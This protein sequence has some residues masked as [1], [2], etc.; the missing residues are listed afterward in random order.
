M[1]VVVVS[2]EKEHATMTS[3]GRIR[4][5]DNP[6]FSG[7]E[8][9]QVEPEAA[10]EAV[11]YFEKK[12]SELEKYVD[13]TLR[14]L[15]QEA[16]KKQATE[17][18][19]ALRQEVASAH[20]I[21]DFQSLLER[22]DRAVSSLSAGEDQAQSSAPDATD[23]QQPVADTAPESAVAAEKTAA[24]KDEA[25]EEAPE[26]AEKA[27]EQAEE[28]PEPAEKTEEQAES[29]KTIK[30]EDYPESLAP[31]VELASKASGLAESSEWGQTQSEF[32]NIRLKW[33][34]TVEAGESLESEEGYSELLKMRDDAEAHFK[35]RKQA[36]QQKRSEQKKANLEKRERILD[37]LQEMIDKKKWQAMK[38]FNHITSRW[39]EI[40]D[41]PKG[42]EAGQQDKRFAE[43]VKQ[44]NDNKVAFLVKKAEKEEENLTG[45]LAVLDKM[46]QLVGS[47]SPETTNWDQ[48]DAEEEEL[49]KQ[50]RK[51]G[52]VPMDQSDQIWDQ[53]KS[54]RDEYVNKKLE[55]NEAFRNHTTKNIRKKTQL[56]EKAEELLEAE[57]LTFAVR[58]I[59]NL[60]KKWKKVGLIPKEKNDELW[61]R[62]NAATRKFNEIKSENQ[63]TIKQQE[64]ANLDKKI[65]LCEKAEELQDSTNWNEI[66]RELDELMKRWKD[67]GPVPRR[68]SG[69]VWKRFKN[70]MD[71]FYE[72]RRKHYRVVREEQKENYRKKREIVSEIEKLGEQENPEE[73]VAGTKEL[74]EQFKEI[75]F[76][77]IKK[78]AKLDKDYK[79]ACDRVYQNF[80]SSGRRS[81][82]SEKPVQKGSDDKSLREQ[83]FKLKKEC[84]KLN[85]EI[86]RSK[87]TMTFINP[88]GKGNALI[89]DIQKKI[90]K[91]QKKLDKKLEK[92]EEIREELDN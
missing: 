82:S 59:N 27:E 92:L 71:V 80:R 53:Y 28:A 38:Q 67:I 68:K 70:A 23:N 83:Y 6:F 69:K 24:D 88:G 52:H 90:D 63:E 79:E 84:D 47:L 60:H 31:L 89:D 12:F 73:A 9:T 14:V 58:E 40:R 86:L 76:V 46:K 54:L 1:T 8:L 37:Q 65:A 35:N 5:K 78:K 51:I 4:Q 66:A 17:A 34:A 74:Q 48:L 42:D 3:D 61:D 20:A 44:F 11:A 91:E 19:E 10:E 41:L 45:K 57:D 50:W 87:D 22:I 81:S 77:P 62:F 56:C 36:W 7:K 64:Q 26:P 18:L 43:L 49:G 15:D 30:K 75:G 16:D 32:D 13:A 29:P 21:G 33:E 85:E 55:Y 72:N 2:M 39:E 25:A